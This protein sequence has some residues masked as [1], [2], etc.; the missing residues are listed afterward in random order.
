MKKFAK[1]KAD[2][3]W[4][5]SA[6]F[7]CSFIDEGAFLAS[8]VSAA[9]AYGLRYNFPCKYVHSLPKASVV[10]RIARRRE[11]VS[12]TPYGS[13]KLVRRR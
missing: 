5:F 3:V 13:S 8:F 9:P 11:L 2:T 4:S 1:Q 6:L 10:R 12:E 7:S